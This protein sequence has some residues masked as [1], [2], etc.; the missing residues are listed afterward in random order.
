MPA[1]NADSIL[2][3][4][5]SFWEC[6]VLLTA[7]ELDLFTRLVPEPLT[8]AEVTRRLHADERAVTILLDALAAMGLLQKRDGRYHCPPDIAAHLTA[9]APASV[10]PMVLHSASL[11][12]RWTEL[13]GVVR[14]DAD[15]VARAQRPRDDAALK[16]FIEAMHVVSGPRAPGIIAAIDPSQARNLLDI[17]GGPG[18]YTI[19]FLKA[20]PQMRATLF[21]RPAVLE[22]AR[23]RLAEAGLLDR[24]TLAGGDFDHAELPSGHDLALL[25]AIIH[26]NSAAQ[27]VDLYRKAW[28]ALVPGGRLVIRD[29]V[30]SPDRLDPPDGALFAVNMLVGTLGG[31]VYTFE[32]IRAGLTTAGFE[33]VRLL[34]RGGGMIGLVEAFKPVK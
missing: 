12:H 15:A 4:A 24:V 21:D 17:G 32:E 22:I 6:R 18:T 2:A 10:L 33:G 23:R 5:R 26:Q 14:G 7:A 1:M 16:A 27:N 20:A 29:H 28:R 25:S 9:N 30:L 11:W 19:A 13:T 3:L 8:A 34:Q 31:N